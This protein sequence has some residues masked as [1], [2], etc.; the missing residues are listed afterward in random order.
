MTFPKESPGVGAGKD[1]RFS[2]FGA[3]VAQQALAPLAGCSVASFLG[4]QTGGLLNVLVLPVMVGIALGFLVW[5]WVPSWRRTGRWIF[6]LP[7]LLFV[8]AFA[9]NWRDPEFFY[10]NSDNEGLAA[11]LITVPA[12]V[13]A[14]YSLCLA[15]ANRLFPRTR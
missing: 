15:L 6:C 2:A 14:G 12:A 5:M 4:V 11:W 3:F 1:S 13:C 9:N 7:S 8:F 10:P